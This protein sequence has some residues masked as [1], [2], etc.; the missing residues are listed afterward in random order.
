[1]REAGNRERSLTLF[2]FKEFGG[3]L[4]HKIDPMSYAV[5]QEQCMAAGWFHQV[6]YRRVWALLKD[7]A[8]AWSEDKVPRHGAALA[9]YTVFSIAPI[10]TSLH[11][12]PASGSSLNIIANRPVI[13]AKDSTNSRKWSA[14]SGAGNHPPNH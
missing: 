5:A 7:T 10:H 1:M 8:T 12:T 3:R 13:R 11:A 9:Y 6:T 14:T 4:V 2:L